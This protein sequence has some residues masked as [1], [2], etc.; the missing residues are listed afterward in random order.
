MLTCLEHMATR[1]IW[2]AEQTKLPTRVSGA[3]PQQAVERDSGDT[4]LFFYLRGRGYI[5]K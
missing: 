1:L 4:V 2:V 3:A 5:K